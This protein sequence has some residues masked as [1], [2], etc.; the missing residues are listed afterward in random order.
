MKFPLHRRL[1]G[2]RV[3][4]VEDEAPIAMLL[5]E[6]LLGAGAVVVG[7]ITTVAGALRVVG[8]IR[9]DHRLDAAARW[10]LRSQGTRRVAAASCPWC[11]AL[12]SLAAGW[13]AGSRR[14]NRDCTCWPRTPAPEAEAFCPPTGR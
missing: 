10:A 2:R 7:P 13:P 11:R 14:A 12:P 9:A 8:S 5:E 3:L 1:K 6:A 4:L